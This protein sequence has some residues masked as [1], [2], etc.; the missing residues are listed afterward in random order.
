MALFAQ[1]EAIARQ[2]FEKGE[3]EKAIVY[4]KKLCTKNPNNRSYLMGLVSSYQ[5]SE[6]Y[7]EAEKVLL[8]K[9]DNGNVYPV[10]YVETGYNY[11]LMGKMQKAETYYNKAIA[12]LDENPNYAYAVGNAFKG[13]TLL[14]NAIATYK[15]AMMLN[16]EF[17]FNYDLAYIYGE[18]GDIENMY[19]MYL[20]LMVERA[21]LV[22]NIK[23]NLSRFIDSNVG[24]ENSALFKK[25]LLKRAQTDPNVLW[26]ELLSWLF[27]QQG[28]YKSAYAQ[29]KA[30]YKRSPETS[31]NSIVDLAKIALENNDAETAKSIYEFIIAESRDTQLLIHSK[32]ELIN[33]DLANARKKDNAKIETAFKQLLAE[34]GENTQTLPVQIAYA[35]FLAFKLSETDMAEARLKKALE[36]PINKYAEAQIRMTLAD[37]LVYDEKFNQA[38][39]YYSQV[40]KDL[41][42][43]VLGQEARFKVAQTSFYKGDFEWAETQLKVLKS[44][45]SQLIANDALQLKLLI[46]DNKLGDTTQVAL[47]LYAEAD[48]LAYQNNDDGAMAILSTI[49]SDHKGEPIEDEAL[50]KQAS[51]FEKHGDY[52]KAVLDYQKIIT[53]YPTDILMDD[54]LYKLA[55][56][57]KNELSKPDEAKQLLERIIYEHQDSIYLIDARKEY[58]SIRGDQVE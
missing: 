50:F 36:L 57:Y 37:I 35:R 27:V 26:N 10:L 31:L 42:N 18:K 58:R 11:Q 20:D 5:Q 8:Q 54:A 44:S 2:Y 34:Y 22:G 17:N 28:Q 45:T 48:L 7:V 25:L 32:L 4:Y 16:P 43:D 49:L 40:Q 14:D 24:N 19:E 52:E 23:R 6:K 53:F 39:I 15:K 9:L 33:I 46:S 21:N 13:K 1:D 30:I 55:M 38:L 3:F 12:T 29:E 51:L 41:K 47:K 56:L